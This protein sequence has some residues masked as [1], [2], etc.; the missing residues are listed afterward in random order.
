MPS[1]DR[2]WRAGGSA[3]LRRGKQ[4]LPPLISA[5]LIAWLVWT[6]QPRRLLDALAATNWPGLLLAAVVQVVVLFLWDTVCVWW[7][8]AQPERR[9]PFHTVLRVRCDTVIWSAVNLEVGQAAFAWR[10]ARATNRPLTSTL[11]YC[12]LLALVDCGTLLSLALVGSFLHPTPLTRP[13][14]WLCLGGLAGL[15]LLVVLLKLLPERWHR[16]LA[17]KPWASWLAWVDWRAVA[18]LG[19]LRLIMFLLVLVYAGVSLAI[20]GIPAGPL[21]VAGVIPFVILA[22]S[23]P[24]TAGLGERETALVYLYPAGAGGRAVLLS[25]GLIWSAVVILGRVLISLVSWCLP[26]DKSAVEGR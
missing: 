8:F 22:E 1:G 12:L 7:L 4:V 11:G 20:C 10:L 21:T 6:I 24:G 2:R 18:F 14:R 25:L 17:E 3:L 15:A 5:G 19:T 13:W 9:L 16:R 23:L 26:R